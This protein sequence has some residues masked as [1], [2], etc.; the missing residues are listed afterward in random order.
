MALLTLTA[1]SKTA[2]QNYYGLDDLKDWSNP[3]AVGTPASIDFD[4][5]AQ[6]A[7][8]AVRWFTQRGYTVDETDQGRDFDII[9]TTV[10]LF[11]PDHNLTETE[12]ELK[13]KL[14]TDFKPIRAA[15]PVGSGIA[16]GEDDDRRNFSDD[17]LEALDNV[18]ESRNNLRT[19]LR[20]IE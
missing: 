18:A 7:S 1:E 8:R 17:Q 12:R 2:I 15:L 5:V 20:G 13:A 16:V 3:R 19:A 14:S 4:A 11:R 10:A 9:R 6:W